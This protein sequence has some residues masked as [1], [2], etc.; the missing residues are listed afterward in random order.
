MLHLSVNVTEYFKAKVLFPAE[1]TSGGGAAGG[2][3]F[4][5]G[6]KS[7]NTETLMLSCVSD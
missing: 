2:G 3:V 6:G 7:R 4:V 1:L 5:C